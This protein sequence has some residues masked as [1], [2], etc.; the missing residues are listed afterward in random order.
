[1]GQHLVTISFN[2]PPDRLSQKRRECARKKAIA[3]RFFTEY[4]RLAAH[5][6]KYSCAHS[7]TVRCKSRRRGGSERRGSGDGSEGNRA[8]TLRLARDNDAQALDTR[9]PVAS[10][11]AHAPRSPAL[12]RSRSAGLLRVHCFRPRQGRQQALFRYVY[13]RLG[14]HRSRLVIDAEEGVGRILLTG[15]PAKLFRGEQWAAAFF[16][17]QWKFK[18]ARAVRRDATARRSRR[19]PLDTL[20]SE[21]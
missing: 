17:I 1:M 12:P 15:P 9:E 11:L 6:S 21:R 7:S 2:Q 18:W 20:C 14:T 8:A 10:F 13:T 16:R 4:R 3:H 19:R 5:Q